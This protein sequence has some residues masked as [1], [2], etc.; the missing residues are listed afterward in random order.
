MLPARPRTRAFI[1]PGL[2]RIPLSSRR[3][4]PGRQLGVA[5]QSLSKLKLS[6]LA[7][8]A[9]AV[10][11]PAAYAQSDGAN[12][13]PVVVAQANSQPATATTETESETVLVTS[14]R[15]LE[16]VQDV[17]IPVTVLSGV[18]VN[19]SGAF[20]VNRLKELIPSVQFYSS[21]PRNTSINIRGL[22]APFGLTN[23]GIEQGVGIYVDDVYYARPASATFDFL[24]VEQIEVLRG[25]QGTLYGKNTTA[26]AINITTRRPS[27]TPSSA[28]RSTSATMASCRP[29]RSISGPIGEHRCRRGC[30]SRAH[31]A[32][33]RST[34]SRRAT[35]STSR[36]I[37]AFAAQLLCAAV[38]PVRRSARG[39]YSVSIQNAARKWSPA[40]RRPSGPRTGNSPAS[41]RISATR[42]RATTP[43]TV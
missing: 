32:T 39:D 36:T 18:Q 1:R 9:A 38:R 7:A 27:F 16:D 17:P 25:P 24:D 15:V 2:G 37:S 6:L 34:T 42:R 20:N 13:A 12:D 22:G 28:S 40:L 23:D 35:T 33:A 41:P 5:M 10:L 19:E 21:N 3:P 29:R 11:V 4:G 30:R 8:S 43:S 14:R 31:S 26:G